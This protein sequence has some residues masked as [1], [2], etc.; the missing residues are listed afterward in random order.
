LPI[1]HSFEPEDLCEWV[2]RQSA[3]VAE[4]AAHYQQAG[5]RLASAA[6]NVLSLASIDTAALRSS[7]PS[8]AGAV[9]L[10]RGCRAETDADGNWHFIRVNCGECPDEEVD[11]FSGV[12]P[13]SC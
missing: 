7:N 13:Y 8:A 5:H 3:Y 11:V 6:L 10:A 9:E 1:L 2:L 4:N 12:A